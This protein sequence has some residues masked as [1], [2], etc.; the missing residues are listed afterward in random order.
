MPTHLGGEVECAAAAPDSRSA[1]G[2][3]EGSR[4]KEEERAFRS[5]GL[6]V[7]RPEARAAVSREAAG[8]GGLM[9]CR[10]ARAHAHAHAHVTCGPDVLHRIGFAPWRQAQGPHGRGRGQPYQAGL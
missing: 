4:S 9:L 6:H 8:G 2:R 10:H 3:W 7:G 1:A 5:K